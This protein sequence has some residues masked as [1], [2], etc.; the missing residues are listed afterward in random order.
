MQ[1]VGSILFGAD[2]AIAEWVRERIPAMAGRD[3]GVC[4]ALGV[5]RGEHL[6]GGVVFSN[7]RHPDIEIS[8]AFTTSAWWQPRVARAIFA[9]PF[10]QLKCARLTLSTGRKNK[11][12]RRFAEHAGFRLEGVQRRGL[13]GREDRMLYGML[14]D[15]C[16]FLRDTSHGR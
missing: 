10:V 3:F 8:A 1:V 6:I 12:A 2:A 13:D 16:R 11:R 4:S 14:M 7:Y 5:V 15:E 9:Y